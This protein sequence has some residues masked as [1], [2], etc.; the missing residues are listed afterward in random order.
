MRRETRRWRERRSALALSCFFFLMIRRPPRSTLFPYTT[1]FRSVTNVVNGSPVVT[2][3]LVCP[4]N[5]PWQDETSSDS[6]VAAFSSRGNVGV[7]VEGDF[8]RFKPDLVAPGTFVVSCRSAQ[9]DEQA[10][11]NPTNHHLLTLA[12]QTVEG[13]N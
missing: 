13:T 4:T 3:I 1:L 10:Y 2:N 11:Y 6:Q 7:T 12:A 9:W 8:G 5:Y